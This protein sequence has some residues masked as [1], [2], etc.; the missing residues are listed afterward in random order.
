MEIFNGC[1]VLAC[2]PVLL[3][4]YGAFLIK[5]VWIETPVPV[6][7]SSHQNSRDF[8]VFTPKYAISQVLI[9][10]SL[11]EILNQ[12]DS[13]I[14]AVRQ[15]SSLW[16]AFQSGS[17]FVVCPPQLPFATPGTP[18]LALRPAAVRPRN[19]RCFI[20]SMLESQD[21][22]PVQQTGRAG[23]SWKIHSIILPYYT[24]INYRWWLWFYEK[25]PI[26]SYSWYLYI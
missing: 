11:L 12:N 15:S 17:F 4:V 9:H 16:L 8:W 5:R 19:S 7:C 20:T 13:I 14:R 6:P 1:I 26:Y 23:K 21:S 3:N 22:Q 18:E 2:V 10:Q 24:S 25:P